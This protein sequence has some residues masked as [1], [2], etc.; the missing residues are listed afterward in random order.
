MND[1]VEEAADDGAGCAKERA[2]DWQRHIKG[3]IYRRH[4]HSR[5]L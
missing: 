4:D 1:D 3:A 2:N 5:S